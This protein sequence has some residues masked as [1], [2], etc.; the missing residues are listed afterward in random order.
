MDDFDIDT[1]KQPQN[2]SQALIGLNNHMIITWQLS[3][4]KRRGVNRG[5]QLS[6]HKSPRPVCL[7]LKERTW[8]NNAWHTEY[9]TKL[10]QIAG[11]CMW[12]HFNK[13]NLI[14]RFMGPI[15]QLTKTMARESRFLLLL[16]FFFLLSVSTLALSIWFNNL[17]T[18]TG[19]NFSSLSSA[20]ALRHLQAGAEQLAIFS[21]PHLWARSAQFL[22]H[23]QDVLHHFV[24]R[25]S[26]EV[27]ARLSFVKGNSAQALQI[28][29]T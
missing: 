23:Y 3:D 14:Y 26:V 29:W 5:S 24:H 9:H 1:W 15:W 11:H 6:T 19:G 21:P 12:D 10:A 25:L 28:A 27:S 4:N 18:T 20:Y 13:Q 2:V 8:S 16:L 17:G 22:I 7:H